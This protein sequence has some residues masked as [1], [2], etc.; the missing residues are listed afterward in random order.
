VS[1]GHHVI[2]KQRVKI[3]VGRAAIKDK[4]GQELSDG[5]RRLLDTPLTTILRDP[6]NIVHLSRTRHHRAHGGFERLKPE[7]LPRGIEE[8]ADDYGLRWALEHEL[9]LMDAA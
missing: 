5:E 6:R 7:E 3:A 2:P 1:E 9:R 4:Q 8:F